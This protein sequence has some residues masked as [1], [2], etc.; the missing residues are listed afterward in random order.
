MNSTLDEM[1]AAWM[2]A[3]ETRKVEALRILKGEV[4][5]PQP[6]THSEAQPLL[7]S[8]GAAA[9]YAGLSRTSLWRV[10]QAGRLE[11]FELLPNSYR[12][13]RADLDAFVRGNGVRKK[14]GVK[15]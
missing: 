8:M 14:S 10:I 6:S 9:K 7:L 5:N 3:P 2:P 13:R 12:I 4:V 1:V 15:S 11:K